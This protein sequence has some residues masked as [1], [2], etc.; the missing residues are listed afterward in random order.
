MQLFDL[1][2]LVGDNQAHKL[3]DLCRNANIATRNARFIY[4]SCTGTSGSSVGTASAASARGVHIPLVSGSS[5]GAVPLTLYGSSTDATDLWDLDNV[6][7]F[8]I[9][10]S[11]VQIT[12]SI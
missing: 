12:F 6:Y 11:S 4:L 1:P 7:V 9:A 5:G 2:D 10:G 3:G 8:A